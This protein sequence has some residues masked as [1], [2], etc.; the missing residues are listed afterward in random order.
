M[1]RL[2]VRPAQPLQPQPARCHVL[3]LL[4][5][6]LPLR[7]LQRHEKVVEAGVPPVLPAKRR[8]QCRTDRS[9]NRSSMM[10]LITVQELHDRSFDLGTQ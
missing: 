1:R 8:T 2:Q 6:V 5:D 4:P 7:L 9:G 3:A 10:C